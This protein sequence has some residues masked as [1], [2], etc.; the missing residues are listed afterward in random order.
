MTVKIRKRK[1]K[2]S[3]SIMLDY[4]DAQGKRVQHVFGRASTAEAIEHLMKRAAIEAKRIELA[5]LEGKQRGKAFRIQDALDDFRL[6]YEDTYF[7]RAS[8]AAYA[9]TC[10][11]FY[12]WICRRT[13]LADITRV[14]PSHAAQFIKY[15]SSEGRAPGT[16][17]GDV[18]RLSRIWK[19]L[20]EQGRCESN[21]WR[22]SDVVAVT[23]AAGMHERAF[24]DEEFEKFLKTIRPEWNSENE[25]H[26]E[27]F[28]IL[29]DTGLRSGELLHLRHCDA[30]LMDDES[31][32]EVRAHD[33]WRPKTAKSAR[34]VPVPVRSLYVLIERG[35][36]P[37][38]DELI[39]PSNW[40]PQ[41]VGY[42]FNRI[43]TLAGLDAP[44]ARYGQKLRV[45]SLRHYY[46]TKL[47]TGGVDVSTIR[48]L[49]GHASIQTTNRYFNAPPEAAVKAVQSVFG[50]SE[51]G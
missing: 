30:Y 50:G 2:T 31:Y 3:T 34:R 15:R 46:A 49:L 45:H 14:G 19:R 10:Q 7:S 43:L 26:H 35:R 20:V 38:G 1:R 17:K 47:V 11:V 39:F 40:T 42:F 41:S 9:N 27:F 5:L 22:H 21:P 13:S 51:S 23:P 36:I 24:T 4:T 8:K 6:F 25:D 29:A 16:V 48:D 33:G 12:D 37:K 28:T 18:V 32:V 44:D